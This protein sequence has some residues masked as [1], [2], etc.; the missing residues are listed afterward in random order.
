MNVDVKDKAANDS[1]YNQANGIC[2]PTDI[3]FY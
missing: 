1:G 3:S 2:F